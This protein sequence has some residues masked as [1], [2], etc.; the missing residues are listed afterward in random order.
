M[1]LF[2]LSPLKRS[3][4]GSVLIRSFAR[5]CRF[6]PGSDASQEVRFSYGDLDNQDLMRSFGFA[7]EGNEADAITIQADSEDERAV[8]TRVFECAGD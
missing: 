8:L 2:S 6:I 3:F 1:R 5:T 7:V 4:L